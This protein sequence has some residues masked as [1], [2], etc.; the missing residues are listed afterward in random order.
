MD[1]RRSRGSQEA[2]RSERSWRERA[3]RKVRL[4][5]DLCDGSSPAPPV[6]APPQATRRGAEA[7]GSES[8]DSDSG[9][10][11]TAS[12]KAKASGRGMRFTRS[13]V[14]WPRARPAELLEWGW[15]GTAARLPRCATLCAVCR[16]G[17]K[18]RREW[19]SPTPGDVVWRSAR[20]LPKSSRRRSS[21]SGSKVQPMYLSLHA[22]VRTKLGGR[23]A[24]RRDG[25]G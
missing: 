1:T 16:A 25:E 12:A 19:A 11:P 20:M 4:A 24:Q 23:T 2:F 14:S 8:G 18:G 17:E 9:R 21:A 5:G 7:E 13:V 10:A 3:A 15:L 6:A 22:Y